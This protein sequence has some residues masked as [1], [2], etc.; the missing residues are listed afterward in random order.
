M[1]KE[2]LKSVK[3]KDG[4]TL[5]DIHSKYQNARAK[6]AGI[7]FGIGT[8]VFIIVYFYINN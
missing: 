5:Y 4:S 1:K 8:I 2:E 6:S 3:F 7:I